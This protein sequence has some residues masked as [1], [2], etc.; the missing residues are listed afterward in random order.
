VPLG[1]VVN[2]ASAFFV[3][4]LYQTSGLPSDLSQLGQFGVVMVMPEPPSVMLLVTGP[5]IAFRRI[6]ARD[7]PRGSVNPGFVPTLRQQSCA[8]KPGAWIQRS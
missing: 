2:D 6:T 3:R 8:G 7:R 4:G 1:Q 5:V